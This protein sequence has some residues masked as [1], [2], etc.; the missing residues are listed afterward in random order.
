MGH[1]FRVVSTNNTGSFILRQVLNKNAN[2]VV[3][4]YGAKLESNIRENK[5]IPSTPLIVLS[6]SSNLLRLLFEI[7]MAAKS[8]IDFTKYFPKTKTSQL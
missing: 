8:S 4:Q 7:R 3:V 1:I 5:S 6:A 2:M